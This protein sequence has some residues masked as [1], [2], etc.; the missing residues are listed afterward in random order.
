[1]RISFSS[2]KTL[3]LFTALIGVGSLLSACTSNENETTELT[4]ECLV[5]RVQLGNMTR[6]LRL[7]TTDGLRDSIIVANVPGSLYAMTIDQQTNTIYNVD[8]LPYNTKVSRVAFAAFS[9]IGT[10]AIRSLVSEKDSIFTTTDST[11]LS[12]PRLFTVYSLDGNSKRT[13]TL[14]LRV[15]KEQG[16][17]ATWKKLTAAEWN[18]QAFPAATHVFSG[19]TLDFKV[20][21]GKILRSTDGT[22]WTTDAL[23]TANAAQLPNANLAGIVLPTRSDKTIEEALLYGTLNGQSRIWKRNID[24]NGS[25]QF[26]WNYLPASEDNPYLAPALTQ[27]TLLAYDDGVLLLGIDA[28]Q[29]VQMRFSLDRG[30]TWKQHDFFKLP[31]ALPK[32]ANTLVAH[33]DANNHLW[34]RIDETI[35]WRGRLN[36]LGWKP[37]QSIFL[38]SRMQ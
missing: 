37:V 28:Q 25:Y 10:P 31:A 21:G 18:A 7:R 38:K 36:H 34:L 3:P 15:H 13:Y 9:A 17:S 32:T 24:T 19:S 4:N 12:R 11:D 8:S 2:L 29:K 16:D 14:D 5:T 26:E 30:R 27:T 22:N 35:V 1:M 23:E 33:V 6:T 20:E